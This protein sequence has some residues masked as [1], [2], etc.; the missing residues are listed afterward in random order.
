MMWDRVSELIEH[1]PS[2]A[3]LREHKLHL[4]AAAQW[5]ATGRPIPA[6][7]RDDERGMAM[8]ATAAPL[9]LRRIRAAYP[10]RLVLMKGP[11]IAAAYPDPATRYYRDLDLL[12]DDPEAAQRALIAAGFVVLDDSRHSHHL[13]PL[14]YPGLP[15]VIEVHREVNRPWWLDG[16]P[17]GEIIEHAVPGATGIPGILAPPP[18]AHAVLLA[19]HAWS[20]QPLWR[21]GDLIDVAVMLSASEPGSAEG[22]ARDW[23]WEKMWATTLAALV[24]LFASRRPSG[25]SRLWARHLVSARQ[26]TVFEQH[27]API[28]GAIASLPARRIPRAVASIVVEAAAPVPGEEWS[29]KLR[30]SRL[31]VSRAGMAASRHHEQLLAGEPK[32]G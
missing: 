32:G 19:G 29:V 9:L 10:G 31:A 17:A 11:E 5:R 27:L 1:A 18:A 2:L 20:H 25:A 24:G 13:A 3:A 12:C 26:R 4:L 28:G 23:G 6:S 30:R 14:A 15:L 16:P 22:I 21:V 8:M 7:V